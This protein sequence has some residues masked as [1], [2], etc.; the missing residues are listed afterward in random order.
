MSSVTSNSSQVKQFICHETDSS[1]STDSS[2]DQSNLL[3]NLANDTRE[4]I[5]SECNNQLT[6]HCNFN[7]NTDR[8]I[9]SQG[10]IKYTFNGQI[11][12]LHCKQSTKSTE[13]TIDTLDWPRNLGH[14]LSLIASQ[15]HI[16][17]QNGQ[18]NKRLN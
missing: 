17:L 11:S 12:K 14:Q 5:T 18:L 15:F 10:Q 1:K 6:N 16:Q 13:P 3:N 8:C 2:V 4:A 9:N 7:C